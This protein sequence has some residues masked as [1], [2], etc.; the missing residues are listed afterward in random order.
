MKKMLITSIFFFSYNVFES[1]LSQGL[2][3]QGLFGKGLV[4]LGFN[5][6]LT[7]KVISWRSVTHMF[8]GYL[9]PVLTQ[10]FFPKPPTTFLTCFCRGGRQKYARKKRVNCSLHNMHL[11]CF[12]NIIEKEHLCISCFSSYSTF[13]KLIN[14]FPNKEF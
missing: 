3:N 1:P 4:V 9:T 2:E 5:A 12:E 6:T 7:T 14:P 11:S 13:C 8:P 10:L